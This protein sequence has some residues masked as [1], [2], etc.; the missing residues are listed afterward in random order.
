MTEP[1][2]SCESVTATCARE[3]AAGMALRKLE[4]PISPAFGSKTAHRSLVMPHHPETGSCSTSRDTA[5]RGGWTKGSEAHAHRSV[6]GRCATVPYCRLLS[7][8]GRDVPRDPVPVAVLLR[9]PGAPSFDATG[10]VFSE[11]PSPGA[12]SGL[13]DSST[14]ALLPETFRTPP[15]QVRWLLRRWSRDGATNTSYRLVPSPGGVPEILRG[16]LPSEQRTS[17]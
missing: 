10:Q 9:R 8:P 14:A 15:P 16:V 7:Y 13:R 5:G 17:E 4:F 11:L 2:T 6:T 3:I 12:L 1:V